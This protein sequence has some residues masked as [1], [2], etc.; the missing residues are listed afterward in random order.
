[1]VSK[2]T[3]DLVSP[4]GGGGGT[5]HLH[6]GELLRDPSNVNSNSYHHFVI[7]EDIETQ[8]RNSLVKANFCHPNE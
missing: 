5:Q 8:R 3:Y 6:E 4:L 2:S 7:G 1:M